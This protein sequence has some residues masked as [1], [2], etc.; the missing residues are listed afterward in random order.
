VTRT[1]RTPASHG[2]YW[3]TVQTSHNGMAGKVTWSPGRRDHRPLNGTVQPSFTKTDDEP[4]NYDAVCPASAFSAGRSRLAYKI[5]PD[6]RERQRGAS[7]K[8]ESFAT[9]TSG[10][11]PK[12]GRSA[13]VRCPHALS[14]MRPSVT[15]DA[16]APT[17]A[18]RGF[19]HWA[20][21]C[22]SPR[23]CRRRVSPRA[24][25]SRGLDDC[26][27]SPRQGRGCPAP[28]LAR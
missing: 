14:G 27:S 16:L 23:R 5:S 28:S 7:H 3:R 6:L 15:V 26:R 24:C 22:C 13:H 8:S 19:C 2:I 9:I 4:Q 12:D 11:D 25:A 18:I 10:V 1:R 21:G 17:S 20:E